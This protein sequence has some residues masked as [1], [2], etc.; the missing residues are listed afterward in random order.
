MGKK[1]GRTKLI[2]DEHMDSIERDFEGGAELREIATKYDVSP[3]TI[4]NWLIASGYKH[5]QKGRYPQAMKLKAVELSNRGW[6]PIAIANLF[7]TKLSYV[8]D[9]IGVASSG[10]ARPAPEM[11]PAY[12]R[13]VVGRRWTDAQ[14]DEVVRLVSTGVFTVDQI[15]RLTNASR[16]RQQRIWAERVG[17]PYPLAR[18]RP[19]RPDRITTPEA[20]QQGRLEGLREARELALQSQAESQVAALVPL[21]QALEVASDA[22]IEADFR[23]FEAQKRQLEEGR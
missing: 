7:R 4:T 15:Y 22:D 18:E 11:E 14:K 2:Y 8:N 21:E 23:R 3:P 17:T 16:V 20:F 6:D 5:R 19:E 12:T 9:W 13:H 10:R 1:W